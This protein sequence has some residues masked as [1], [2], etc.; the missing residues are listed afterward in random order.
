MLGVNF[1]PVMLI[2]IEIIL[3]GHSINVTGIM[4]VCN[5]KRTLPECSEN[6]PCVVAME[7]FS[8]TTTV[9]KQLLL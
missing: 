6:V 7:A 1:I 9:C 3:N 2:E 4:F 8:L 5:F